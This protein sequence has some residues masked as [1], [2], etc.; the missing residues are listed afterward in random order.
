MDAITAFLHGELNENIYILQ[1]EGFTDGSNKVCKLKKSMYGLKQSSRVWN[2]KLNSVLV[3]FGLTRSNVDQ[4]VYFKIGGE[5]ILI[6]AIY[7]DDILIFSNDHQVEQKLKSELVNNFKIKD[8]GEASSVLGMRITR[9]QEAGTI[10]IDQSKYIAEV[11]TR[12]GMTDSNPVSTPL[13]LNQK[14]SLEMSPKTESEKRE[15]RQVPYQEAIG[16]IMYAAQVT[17]PDICFAVSTLSRYNNNPGKPHWNAVKRV[18]RYLKGTINNKLTYCRNG[19]GLTGFCDA[20]WGGDCDYRRSTT[21]YIFMMQS[22][23][24]S[25]NSKKQPT[26]ALSTTEAEFMSMV[27][28]IQESIWIKNF[29]QE[30]FNDASISIVLH[31]DNK[32]AINLA[33]NNVYHAKTKHIDIKHRFIQEKLAEGR[34]KLQYLQTNE[35]IADV[36]TKPIAAQKQVLFSKSFGL[37]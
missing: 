7:V 2:E 19:S 1:P 18:M 3:N 21:G 35:M 5:S 30:I 16:S 29:D 33:I 8:M 6:L 9:D 20:D 4:C 11:L 17:R 37:F 27:A 32:S 12:F 22:A 34:I 25:W 28:A 14:I 26:V 23:A 10:S 24:I 31:C 36:M 15:M 13:D